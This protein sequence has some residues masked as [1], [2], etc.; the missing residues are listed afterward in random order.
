MEDK[1][2]PIVIK[3]IIQGGHGH[4]GGSWKVAFA[5][6]AV[7]MMAFFMVLWLVGQ[8][9]ANKRGGIAE[10]F[11]NPSMVR[12]HSEAPTGSI[13]P[14]GAGMSLISFGT[15]I[16]M[17]KSD[18]TII[19]KVRDGG[20]AYVSYD[21]LKEQKRLEALMEELKEQVGQNQALEPFKDQLLLE[22][23]PNGL[24]IQVVDK[25]DRPMFDSGSANLKY[26]TE[27][28]LNEL[29]KTINSVPNKITI[30]GHTDASPMSK[31]KG[32]Y[33]NWELSSDRANAARRALIEGGLKAE[34][35]GRVIGLAST[36][37]FDKE[38]PFN[39]INRRISIVIMKREVSDLVKQ[40][41]EMSAIPTELIQGT[42]GMDAVKDNLSLPL[43][44][45]SLEL[46]SNPRSSNIEATTDTKLG[47]DLEMHGLRDDDKN[48]GAID[49]T[50]KPAS[51]TKTRGNQ[52]DQLPASFR[53]GSETNKKQPRK[54]REP[55]SFIQLPPI[56]D[57][58]LLP[59]R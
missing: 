56:I 34:K 1:K 49:R 53:D 46:Q 6:F 23:T 51:D 37:L 13:G 7:A 31:R 40:D 17:Q 55:K 45:E 38:D 44:S 11:Q 2:Q 12:G 39:S 33:T 4:H 48:T 42:A 43:S 20:M 24:R 14:G 26:Y 18:P 57:P 29:A 28:I 5:D 8:T 19:E 50:N 58:S 35:I 47:M 59:Q 54:R 30:S 52:S 3:K 25:K 22:V 41:D 36:I 9:D 21:K 10:Y 27:A 32:S 15:S 16:E